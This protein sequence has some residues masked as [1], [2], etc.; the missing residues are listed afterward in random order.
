[1]EDDTDDH[2][3]A[4]KVAEPDDDPVLQDLGPGKT[5]AR[6]PHD[7]KAVTRE[8]LGTRDD[9]ADEAER[10]AEAAENV[11]CG[12]AERRVCLHAGH[13][14]RTAA[15]EHACHEREHDGAANLHLGLCETDGLG[16]LLECRARKAVRLGRIQILG[17]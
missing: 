2:E 8:Q 14:Q 15:D 3:R 11:G 17:P 10:E 13:E 4:R 12:K 1:M 9:H 7:H 5:L 16:L 6:S